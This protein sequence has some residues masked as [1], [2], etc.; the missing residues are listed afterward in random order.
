MFGAELSERGRT[1]CSHDKFDEAIAVY[2][3]ALDLLDP[4]TNDPEDV[5]M[6][7]LLADR[8]LKT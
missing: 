5:V 7:E 8:T 1:L 6:E 2:S 4:L 3:K